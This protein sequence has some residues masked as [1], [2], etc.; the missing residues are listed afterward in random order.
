MMQALWLE[1]RQ[2]SYRNNL[3]I[4]KPN[5][6]E[7]LIRVRL[8]GICATDLELVKGYYPYTGILGHE[9]VGEIIRARERI[10]ERVV[11]EINV[12][13][14][15]CSWCQKGESKHCSQRSV[16]GIINRS[17]A[18]AEYLC[19]PLKNLWTV[20]TNVSDEAAVFTE[21]LA[22]A[23]EIQEQILL[24]PSHRV[25]IVGAGRLGQLIVQVLRLTGCSLHV[26][27]R[28]EKQQKLLDLQHIQWIDEQ[29]LPL[30]FFDI[31]VE[32]T[33]TA[34][35]LILARK[36]VRPGGT[37]ILKSTYQGETPIN[38]SSLVVEE[39]SLIGSRCGPFK[40][41]LRLLE[42]QLVEPTCLIEQQ[43]PLRE[44][45][46]AFKKAQSPGTFKVLLNVH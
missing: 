15:Q 32:V 19:L 28:Y 8:A 24:R 12:G 44:G 41:A 34:T 16:L 5:E 7:A 36:A 37:I 38:L 6:D 39:I 46:A 13:C 11:G 45:I 27:S 30:R 17:G 18:F 14:G 4:P 40:P 22:A 26:V 20:P 42:K 1:D 3:P 2:L 25:L 35:G 43:F 33:G 23:L 31:V 9:F 29:T 21:P 10:G